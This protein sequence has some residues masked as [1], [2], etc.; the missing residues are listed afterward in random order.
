MATWL[1][2]QFSRGNADIGTSYWYH[3]P[4]P[5]WY[6]NALYPEIVGGGFNVHTYITDGWL[7]PTDPDLAASKGEIDVVITGHDIPWSTD[8]DAHEPECWSPNGPRDRLFLEAGIRFDHDWLTAYRAK[9][10]HLDPAR[11]SDLLWAENNYSDGWTVVIWFDEDVDGNPTPGFHTLYLWWWY[12][13]DVGPECW[14]H[15]FAETDLF[16]GQTH[17]I[18]AEWR[19]STVLCDL[20]TYVDQ[21]A[22]LYHKDLAEDGEFEVFWDGVSLWSATNLQVTLNGGAGWMWDAY[23]GNHGWAEEG[24]AA[25]TRAFSQIGQY[26]QFYVCPEVQ[27]YS[28]IKAGSVP[29]WLDIANFNE[30]LLD[31]TLFNGRIPSVQMDLWTSNPVATIQARLL[32]GDA[33]VSVGESLVVT[34]ATPTK[35]DFDVV[36]NAGVHP[37]RLQVTSETPSVDL[38]AAGPGLVE[39]PGGEYVEMPGGGPHAATYAYQFLRMKDDGTDN[40]VD[41]ETVTLGTQVYTFKDTLSNVAGYVRIGTAEGGAAF[42]DGP[43]SALVDSLS[44]LI[45]AINRSGTPGATYAEATVQNTLARA[46]FREIFGKVYADGWVG[47]D[48][49]IEARALVAGSAGNTIACLTS[50]NFPTYWGWIGEGNVQHDFLYNGEDATSGTVSDPP[51]NPRPAWWKDPDSTVASPLAWTFPWGAGSFTQYRWIGVSAIVD[52]REGPMAYAGYIQGDTTPNTA[53][54][55]EWGEVS[56]AT[57]YR[58]YVFNCRASDGELFDPHLHNMGLVVAR[59]TGDVLVQFTE[60]PASP[61]NW[62]GWPPASAWADP[63]QVPDF[64]CDISGD[65]DGTAWVMWT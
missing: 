61:A 56:G 43:F 26:N 36:L 50:R 24:E 55:I 63:A 3:V 53:A 8:W 5:T 6:P 40:F 31:S 1:D 28:Y 37:Y 46:F 17:I 11:A 34:G 19:V 10:P 27:A 18:R 59:G 42:T 44:H 35:V 62:G 52:T 45:A 51:V 47:V 20:A 13:W 25:W 23:E 38:F 29:P 39:R 12:A 7:L 57:A 4:A 9:Y 49:A 60:V 22:Y 14:I 32:D 64:E 48:T 16:D 21:G 30:V 2:M 41:G 15:T 54:R 58:V 65:A 33:A